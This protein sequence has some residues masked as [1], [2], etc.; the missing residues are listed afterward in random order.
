[1]SSNVY[2]VT[3]QQISHF[4]SQRPQIHDGDTVRGQVLHQTG[5]NTYMVSLGGTQITAKST[6]PLKPGDVFTAKLSVAGDSVVLKLIQSDTATS[7]SLKLSAAIFD[8]QNPAVVSLLQNLGLPV[9]PEALALVQFALNMGVK[10]DSSRINRALVKGQ[11]KDGKINQEKSQLSLIAEEKSIPPYP[12]FIESVAEWTSGRNKNP[13]DRGADKKS[14]TVTAEITAEDIKNLFSDA[15]TA[16]E[17]HPAGKL[18]AFNSF[19]AR[20]GDQWFLLPFE[21]DFKNY[22]GVIRVLTSMDYK[23][24]KKVVIDCHNLRKKHKFVIYFKGNKVDSIKAGIDG[25]SDSHG[26]EMAG[27]FKKFLNDSELLKKSVPVT[28]VPYNQ[29]NGFVLEDTE[30]SM[31]NMSV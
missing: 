3:S 25:M 21:W 22:N 5:K 12:E 2:I 9:I 18:T 30:L 24:L 31:V 10:I 6:V 16:A 4:S 11:E 8:N 14:P 1:M 26:V 28:F 27:E 17:T 20:N 15:D 7:S 13:E 19:K 23:T 29:M